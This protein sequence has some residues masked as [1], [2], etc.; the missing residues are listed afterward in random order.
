VGDDSLSYSTTDKR[1]ISKDA[2]IFIKVNKNLEP[3]VNPD[4][5]EVFSG[6][7]SYIDVLSNDQDREQDSIFISEF[8]QPVYGKLM[9]VKNQLVYQV[10]NA[11]NVI[12]SFQYC[13]SDGKS[14]SAKATVKINVKSKSDPCYPWLSNDLGDVAMPGSLSVSG[15]KMTVTASGSDIWG[16]ADGFGFTCQMVHGDCEISAKVESLEASHEWAKAGVMIR[17]SLSAGSPLAMVFASTKHGINTH[18]REKDYDSMQGCE[19]NSVGSAPWWIKVVR[20]GIY[21]LISI[22]PT[23]KHGNRWVLLK[24]ICPMMFTLVWQFVAI[25]MA[26]WAK[27][28]LVIIKCWAKRL[29]KNIF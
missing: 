2:F 15:G 4:Q 12:D 7:F 16:N 27:W 29:S 19:S 11:S 14:I 1:K 21:F 3:L 5:A 6:G 25:I 20:K 8:S 26:N 28:C 24:S 13:A 10:S 23:A 9:Q 17:A 22:Q 18:F